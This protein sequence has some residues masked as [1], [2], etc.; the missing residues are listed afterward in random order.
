MTNSLVQT[1]PHVSFLFLFSL[2]FSVGLP[3]FSCWYIDMLLLCFQICISLQTL[4]SVCLSILFQ[5]TSILSLEKVLSTYGDKFIPMGPY[6]VRKSKV[7]QC[8]AEWLEKEEPIQKKME[9]KTLF[10]L[11]MLWQISCSK[12]AVI[13]IALRI[14]A[15]LAAT[16]KGSFCWKFTA[17][18]WEYRDEENILTI[19]SSPNHRIIGV[20]T[21]YDPPLRL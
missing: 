18:Q 6:Y 16:V 8:W 21:N 1:N 11:E 3:R 19:I 9:R 5:L 7:F 17:E 14:W 20:T 2:P 10:W 13:R 12:Q 4:L 15:I